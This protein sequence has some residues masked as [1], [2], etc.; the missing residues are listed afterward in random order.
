MLNQEQ[1]TKWHAIP[2]ILLEHDDAS[3]VHLKPEVREWVNMM[4]EHEL[5]VRVWQE[6]MINFMDE[7]TA[8]QYVL[9]FGVLK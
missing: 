1:Q 6:V 4:N 5:R 7:A 8:A 3:G 9:R 2:R